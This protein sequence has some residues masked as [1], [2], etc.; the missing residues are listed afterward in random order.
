MND[1]NIQLCEL[2]EK[3]ITYNFPNLILPSIDSPSLFID[4]IYNQIINVFY[5]AEASNSKIQKCFYEGIAEYKNTSITLLQFALC[6]YDI[7]SEFNQIIIA[8][9]S[10]LICAK[11][12]ENESNTIENMYQ[13]LI[14]IIKNLNIDFSLIEK[15]MSKILNNFNSEDNNSNDSTI[16]EEISGFS[17]RKDN[18]NSLLVLFEN[19]IY[20]KENNKKN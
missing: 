4:S 9:A 11:E 16:E 7:Y 8:L 6:E 1:I 12:N 2:A 3:A 18:I 19:D 13:N 5:S 17:F 14:S 15:C 10:C 20:K